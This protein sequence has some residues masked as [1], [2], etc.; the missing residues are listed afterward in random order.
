[1]FELHFTYCSLSSSNQ[2]FHK[3]W[4]PWQT[5]ISTG[6]LDA[7]QEKNKSLLKRLR[8]WED[9]AS[10]WHSSEQFLFSRKL[11]WR[12]WGVDNAGIVMQL[13]I[14]LFF[15]A[16]FGCRWTFS[17]KCDGVHWALALT[18]LMWPWLRSRKLSGVFWRC[19]LCTN[20]FCLYFLYFSSSENIPGSVDDAGCV[21]LL[22]HNNS[23]CQFQPTPALRLLEGVFLLF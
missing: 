1:M 6:V 19:W 20:F 9:I 23:L 22:F 21:R 11:C 14:C 3:Y 12:L 17:S 2:S 10:F 16:I 8:K 13:K 7:F 5:E 4:I 15:S 18:W